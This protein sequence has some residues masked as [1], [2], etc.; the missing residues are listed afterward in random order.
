[1]ASEPNPREPNS[2]LS[3]VQRPTAE[4]VRMALESELAGRSKE[5]GTLLQEAIEQ[6]P[7]DASARWQAGQVCVDGE[8]LSPTEVAQAARKDQ[9]LAEY[10]RLRDAA[11][12]NVADQATLAR[13]CRKNRLADE[14]R[15]QWMRVLQLQPNNGEAIQAL[16]LRPYRG[17]MATLEQIKQ[18]KEQQRSVRKAVER[19]RPVVTQWRKAAEGGDPAM[20]AEVREQIV[21]I[22]SPAEM[23]ALEADLWQQVGVKRKARLYHDMTLQM[24]RALGANPHPAAA[25][26]LARYAAFSGFDDVRA[27]AAAGLKRHPLDH[28]APL[29]LSGLQ[30]PIEASLRWMLNDVG[31][32]VTQ[33][34]FYQEGALADVSYALMVSPVYSEADV[35]P[36]PVSVTPGTGTVAISGSPQARQAL[37][38]NDPGA[39]AAAAYAQANADA[40]AVPQQIANA[41]AHN[42]VAAAASRRLNAQRALG[43]AA[44]NEAAVRDAVDRANR[45]IAERNAQIVAVLHETTGLDLGDQPMPW[46]AWWWQ[47]YNEMYTVS[48]STDQLDSDESPKPEYH[49][50]AYKPYR[51]SSASFA[52]ISSVGSGAVGLNAGTAG[53]ASSCFAPGTKVWTLVGQQPIEKIQVGDRV[54]AQ[55]VET[56]ELAYKPVLA[57]TMRPPARW[58]KLG[59]GSEAITATPS[60]PFWASG[61][62]WQMTKQLK[63]GSLVHTLSGSVPVEKVERMKPDSSDPITAYNLIVADFSSYFVGDRGTLVHDNTARK[64]TV[65][66]LPGLVGRAGPTASDNQ[67]H[68]DRSPAK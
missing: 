20:P 13:W 52:P 37:M 16:G 47:D 33:C 54:L 12:P 19:W 6:S 7:G 26:S 48:S 22:G 59:F 36:V 32:L 56:G 2:R 3:T 34:S 24:M 8:W 51:G 21:K 25:E 44:R 65:A 5:R 31:D 18:F 27:A 11:L 10:A 1:V 45:R 68:V 50:D 57:V 53:L 67:G 17:M 60:H 15:V 61:K 35:W 63:V 58:M 14:Q 4:L 39:A 29:L 55:D 30:S 43:Q 64:P 23:V 40:A 66:L 42:A 46:W 38:R 9:R 49:Y 62:G 41:K 28:Y